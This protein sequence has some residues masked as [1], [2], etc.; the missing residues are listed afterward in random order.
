[1]KKVVTGIFAILFLAFLASCSFS[2]AH[3]D[4]VKMCTRIANNQ[5]TQDNPIFSTGTPEIFISCHLKNAPENTKVRFDWNY[6]GQ[7]KF[8]IRSVTLNSGDKIG[9]LNLQAS[10]SRPNNGWP[11][12]DYE[13]AISIMDTDKEPVIK[14]FSVQ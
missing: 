4:D 9:T 10:L 7:K 3:I 2:T 8:T 14:K 5:C 13:V 6:Y 11:K 12:G 1:M